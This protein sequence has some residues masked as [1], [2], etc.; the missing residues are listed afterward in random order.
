MLAD[1]DLD[2]R[3]VAVDIADGPPSPADLAS[4]D[5]ATL[6][7]SPRDDQWLARVWELARQQAMQSERGYV[8][9]LDEIQKIPSWSAAVKGLW[10]A[11]RMAGLALHVVIAGSAPLLMQQGL[12]E[13]LAG[14]FERIRLT[15]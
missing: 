11:D 3:Y 10:D 6:P 13:S 8:L 15:H 2:S 14:R 7:G 12:T 5:T 4:K 9:A 1:I